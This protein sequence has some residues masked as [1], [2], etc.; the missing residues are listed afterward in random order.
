MTEIEA[1]LQ[2][3]DKLRKNLYSLLED[4]Y[5]DLTDAEVVAASQI[6]NAALVKY[7][8]IIMKKMKN[9]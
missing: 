1:L 4:K 2:D 7:N 3:I 9:K 5:T 8:E 6:L